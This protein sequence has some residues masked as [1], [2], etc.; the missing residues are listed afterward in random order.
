MYGVILDSAAAAARVRK[1]GDW[2]KT[3]E[4]GKKYGWDP[5]GIHFGNFTLPNALLALLPFNNMQANPT[6]NSRNEQAIRFDVMYHGQ[7]A[8]TEDQFR[9]AVRRIRERKEKEHT[10]ELKR[11]TGKD[12]SSAGGH[13]PP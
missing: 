12:T 2:T 13:T 9:D 4:D 11:R 8:I 6:F 3:T 7:M 5:Q 1:P 10:E